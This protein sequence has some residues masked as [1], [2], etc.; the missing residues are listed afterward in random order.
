MKTYWHIPGPKQACPTHCWAFYKYDGSNLRFEWSRRQGWYKFGARY[1][2]FDG[3][4]RQWGHAVDLFLRA[5]GDDLERVFRDQASY[6]GI[7]R[8]TAYCEH[9]GPGSFAGWHDYDALRRAGELVLFDVAVHKR[10]F[11]LPADFLRD[12]GHL[13]VPEVVY[14]GPFTAEF[15]EGVRQGRYPVREG[16]V[17]KGIALGKKQ[18]PQHGLWMAKVKTR[19]W[20]AELRRRAAESDVFRQTLEENLREQGCEAA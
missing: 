7:E 4:S 6:R 19:W 8:A 2:V 5:Y 13:R 3:S 18:N 1:T 11:V 12:F 9:F 14:E 17:A 10:G 15:V 20:L 16:V